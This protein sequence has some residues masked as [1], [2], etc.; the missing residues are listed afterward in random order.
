M[1][2]LANIIAGAM[3]WV[4]LI[5]VIAYVFVSVVLFNFKADDGYGE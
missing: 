3:L 2:K 4:I 1:G 5:M